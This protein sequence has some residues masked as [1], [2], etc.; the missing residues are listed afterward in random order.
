MGTKHT[1]G[2]W[3]IDL[4]GKLECPQIVAGIRR[5]ADLPVSVDEQEYANARLIAICGKN[6]ATTPRSGKLNC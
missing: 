2:P 1:A 4:V 3:T 6:T 5:I